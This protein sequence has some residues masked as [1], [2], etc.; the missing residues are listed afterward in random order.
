MSNTSSDDAR[1]PAPYRIRLP[2]FIVDR[3]IGLGDVIKKGVSYFGIKPCSGCDA[4]R[5]RLNRRVAFIRG[6]PR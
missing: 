6:S 2:G 5:T 1:W 4:R 3:E